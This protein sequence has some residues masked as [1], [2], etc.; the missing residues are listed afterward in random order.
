MQYNEMEQNRVIQDEQPWQV[1]QSGNGN[2]RNFNKTQ[3]RNNMGMRTSDTEKERCA[4]EVYI[5]IDE[6]M[7]KALALHEQLADY[8][9]F[10]G[11]Q[12]FKRKLEYQYMC[13]VAEKRKLHHKY[14][15]IHHKIIQFKQAELPHIIP[16][17]WRRYTT[18]DVNDN[19]LPRYVK[20]AMQTYKEWEEKTKQLYEDLWQECISYGMTADAEYISD[21]VSDVTKEIKKVNRMCEQLNGT[22]YEATSIHTM[23][24]KIHEKYKK[25]YEDE[26][27]DKIIRKMKKQNKTNE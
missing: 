21:L 3:H 15:N 24:D 13:E 17:D 14:T 26:Y 27:T 12:G 1:E 22:G 9:C 25:K 2:D 8:F 16:S 6:H 5:E 4:E 23:Q 11:L 20:S 10:L 19:V 18:N 7:Q